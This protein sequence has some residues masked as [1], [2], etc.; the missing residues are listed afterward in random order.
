HAGTA[1]SGPKGLQR[2]TES[3]NA[4]ISEFPD[5]SPFENKNIMGFGATADTRYREGPGMSQT[6]LKVGV[7]LVFFTLLTCALSAQRQSSDRPQIEVSPHSIGV[8]V[9]IVLATV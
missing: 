4:G 3:E 2:N 7:A 8:D 5:C 6:K 1:R 9:D